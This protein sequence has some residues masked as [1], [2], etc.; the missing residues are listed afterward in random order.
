MINPT[1]KALTFHLE[2]LKQ[3]GIL[4]SW[5]ALGLLWLTVGNHQHKYL[6]VH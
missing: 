5:N 2:T 3:L 6:L 1:L 4:Y